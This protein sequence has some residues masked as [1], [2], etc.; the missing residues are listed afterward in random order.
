MHGIG[1]IIIYLISNIILEKINSLGDDAIKQ[2]K[3]YITTFINFSSFI[4]INLTKYAF[5]S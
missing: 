1:I 2:H 4:C 5:Q 3:I